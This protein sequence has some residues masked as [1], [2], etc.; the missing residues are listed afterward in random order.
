MRHLTGEEFGAV[1]L[2][3]LDFMVDHGY[4][5]VAADDVRDVWRDDAGAAFCILLSDLPRLG[6]RLPGP[7]WD[8]VRAEIHDPDNY[9]AFA[10]YAD[11]VT[12]F[13]EDRRRTE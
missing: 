8:R 7:L 2:D 4:P 12:A 6:V 13:Q 5:Q 11:A 3:L 1:V 10:E 9:G